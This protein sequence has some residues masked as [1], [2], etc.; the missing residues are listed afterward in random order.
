MSE[1]IHE[2]NQESGVQ[3]S[4]EE[5]AL[6]L[7]QVAET[8]QLTTQ[9]VL[10]IKE[11]YPEK[12]VKDISDFLQIPSNKVSNVLKALG[13]SKSQRNSS[14]EVNEYI[15]NNYGK[16]KA[17]EIGEYLNMSERMVRSIAAELGVTRKSAVKDPLSES[18][19]KYIK[20][21]YERLSKAEM[22]KKLN[23]TYATILEACVQMG[24]EN[25]SGDQIASQ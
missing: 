5:L 17:S 4:G 13:L 14:P 24:L 10:Y 23:R 16:V 11:N 19:M 15:K 21:H 9:E 7:A 12:R 22:A 8:T 18:E 2:K 6:M 3:P 1:S 20:T 25:P